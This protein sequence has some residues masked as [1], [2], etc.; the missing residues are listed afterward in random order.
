MASALLNASPMK[1]LP[2]P[3]DLR[4]IS[5]PD[6]SHHRRGNPELT[7]LDRRFRIYSDSDFNYSLL[8]IRFSSSPR[9]LRSHPVAKASDHDPTIITTMAATTITTT[10]AEATRS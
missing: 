2:C 7:L 5:V 4:Q 1:A 8:R 10:T 6:L 3:I 9:D